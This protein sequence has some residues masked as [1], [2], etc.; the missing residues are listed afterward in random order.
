MQNAEADARRR[1]ARTKDER[2]RIVEQ[3]L[4]DGA[5]VK[6]VAQLHGIRTNQVFHWRKLYRQGLLE[7]VANSAA[8]T[9]LVPISISDGAQQEL[10]GDATAGQQQIAAESPAMGTIHVESARGSMSINGVADVPTVR[11]VLEY[12]LG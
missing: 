11:A 4:I 3:T 6:A 8:A 2:R 1:R 10:A 9:T 5:S 12:L 7:D